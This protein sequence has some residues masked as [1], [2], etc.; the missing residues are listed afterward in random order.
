MPPRAKPRVE[1]VLV[2]SLGE[3]GLK[4]E[5]VAR[6]T[7]FVLIPEA[8]RRDVQRGSVEFLDWCELCVG[9]KSTSS[10]RR[11]GIWM[12]QEDWVWTD[13]DQA[14]NHMGSVAAGRGFLV[15]LACLCVPV[16][17][18][19]LKVLRFGPSA[20]P[21]FQKMQWA[22]PWSEPE[23]T[24]SDV[25]FEEYLFVQ[26]YVRNPRRSSPD[27]SELQAHPG[28][29]KMLWHQLAMSELPRAAQKHPRPRG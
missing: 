27:E 11:R 5:D 7:P 24:L 4:P 15:A 29:D 10:Q 8:G 19:S 23:T 14:L 25:T 13:R 22:V 26:R 17:R 16:M 28:A 1:T 6:R 3:S 21:P 9:L 18:E 12:H 20:A 2:P